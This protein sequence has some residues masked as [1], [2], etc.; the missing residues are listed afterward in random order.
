MSELKVNLQPTSRQFLAKYLGFCAKSV[1]NGKLQKGEF[2]I[3]PTLLPNHS[4]S[5][6]L[7]D[8]E[9]TSEFWDL[10]SGIDDYSLTKLYPE[11]LYVISSYLIQD[12]FIDFKTSTDHTAYL[13]SLTENLSKILLPEYLDRIG[14]ITFYEVPFGT[15]G[16]F[17]RTRRPD[18]KF[19]I[20]FTHRSDMPIQNIGRTL[21]MAIYLTTQSGFNDVGTLGWHR[22]NAIVDFL[23]KHTLLKDFVDFQTDTEISPKMISDSQLF[24]TKLGIT[25]ANNMNPDLIRYHLSPNEHKL[26]DLLWKNQGA[27]IT[28]DEA[29]DCIWG[30]TSDKFS[31]EALAKLVEGIR[32]KIRTCGINTDPIK[33]LRKRGYLLTA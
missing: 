15:L 16:S 6:Y 2:V 26:F 12:L 21:L 9:Y 25:Y 19:D 17:S 5:M 1:Q 18:G 3:L 29:G 14:D 4:K 33:T 11:K 22:R 8:L 20:V 7:P 27:L 24:L 13:Q 10:V 30:D 32:R 31:L 23:A 28:F